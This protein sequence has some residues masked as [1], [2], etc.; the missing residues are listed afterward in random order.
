[1]GAWSF[2]LIQQPVESEPD[3]W[4]WLVSRI[5]DFGNHKEYKKDF[6][7]ITF[8]K[9][10]KIILCDIYHTK[11]IL[12]KDM[13]SQTFI[14]RTCQLQPSGSHSTGCW[15]GLKL[16][17][18]TYIEPYLMIILTRIWFDHPL[19]QTND[20]LII[21]FE[22]KNHKNV[23]LVLTNDKCHTSMESYQW[24]L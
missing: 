2:S 4:S 22:M 20:F 13:V 7:I 21:T 17:A 1:M 5:Y 6:Y 8:S 9:K 12:P 18:P 10:M 11:I 14:W 24:V 16:H 23:E 3:G 19:S 15:I